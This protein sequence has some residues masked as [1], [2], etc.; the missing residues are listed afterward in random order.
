[1]FDLPMVKVQLQIHSRIVV[2]KLY[3]R[4]KRVSSCFYNTPFDL[5]KTPCEWSQND[6]MAFHFIHFIIIAIVVVTVRQ[7]PSFGLRSILFQ[8][9]G[10]RTVELQ[11]FETLIKTLHL[12]FE[13]ASFQMNRLSR[14]HEE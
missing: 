7:K 5:V 8:F 4:R 3:K 10:K 9:N 14:M 1:M 11:I 6:L 2:N 12:S 13:F